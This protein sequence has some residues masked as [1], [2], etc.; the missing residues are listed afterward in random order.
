MQIVKLNS[1]YPF[2]KYITGNKKDHP[3]FGSYGWHF[4]GNKAEKNNSKDRETKYGTDFLQILIKSV[5][6][7]YD[8][9]CECHGKQ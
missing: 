4:F 8:K 2:A 9:G 5:F 3:D 1:K 6:R 7:K